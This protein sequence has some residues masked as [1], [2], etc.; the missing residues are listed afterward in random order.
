MEATARSL[1]KLCYNCGF[2]KHAQSLFSLSL[3]LSLSAY[4][5]RAAS[6]STRLHRSRRASSSSKRFFWS[7]FHFS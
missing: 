1:H 5:A 4:A 3:S 7:N 6:E 2:R